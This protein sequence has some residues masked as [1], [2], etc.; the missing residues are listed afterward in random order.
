MDQLTG[1]LS[2]YLQGFIHGQVVQEFLPS[3]VLL[4]FISQQKPSSI[5]QGTSRHDFDLPGAYDPPTSLQDPPWCAKLKNKGKYCRK[6][7]GSGSGVP[8]KFIKL[9]RAILL[10][11]VFWTVFVGFAGCFLV[12]L[13]EIVFNRV[14]CCVCWVFG[15][16]LCVFEIWAAWELSKVFCFM[17]WFAWF[18]C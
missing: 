3:T 18:L 2:H 1:S 14:G 5:C 4:P 17:S 15:L 7:H 6:Y 9:M 11:S 16:S 10:G 13:C 8:H 12:E